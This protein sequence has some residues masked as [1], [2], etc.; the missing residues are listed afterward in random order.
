MVLLQK[1]VNDEGKKHSPL[2]IQNN[3]GRHLGY[4][5]TMYVCTI[6]GIIVQNNLQKCQKQLY[7]FCVLSIQCS[8][9]ILPDIWPPPTVS[10]YTTTCMWCIAIVIT[11]IIRIDIINTFLSLIMYHGSKII[12]QILRLPLLP[13]RLSRWSITNTNGP[14]PIFKHFLSSKPKKSNFSR[15]HAYKSTSA[16][17]AISQEEGSSAHKYNVLSSLYA[18]I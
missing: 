2:P 14:A 17:L 6:P 18:P 8:A 4:V 12:V 3:K 7:P 5:A 13:W 15:F 11:I 9:Y 10:P 16:Y 1:H